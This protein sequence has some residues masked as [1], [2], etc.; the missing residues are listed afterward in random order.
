MA[1][2]PPPPI[3]APR[4]APNIGTGIRAWPAIAPATPPAIVVPMPDKSEKSLL[5]KPLSSIITGTLDSTPNIC[6]ASGIKARFPKSSRV[7]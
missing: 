1:F 3:A 2:P 7:N 4:T 6:A 5:V